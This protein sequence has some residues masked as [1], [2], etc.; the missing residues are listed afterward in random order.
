MNYQLHCEDLIDLNNK[1]FHEKFGSLTPEELK[2]Y[3]NER[4]DYFKC[5]YT[6]KCESKGLPLVP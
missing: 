6:A 1:R 4:S 3:R 5:W 2:A